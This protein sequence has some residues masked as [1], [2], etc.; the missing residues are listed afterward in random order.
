MQ[1]DANTYQ[2]HLDSLK[3]QGHEIKTIGSIHHDERDFDSVI[4]TTNAAGQRV[5][6]TVAYCDP[7]FSQHSEGTYQIYNLGDVAKVVS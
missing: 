3:A 6:N 1:V 5:R 2:K 4:Y 7:A